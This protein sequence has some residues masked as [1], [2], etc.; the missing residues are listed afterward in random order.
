MVSTSLPA[1]GDTVAGHVIVRCVGEGAMGVV[2]E[3]VGPDGKIVA[4][5]LLKPEKSAHE[6]ILN[7]FRNEAEATG[8]VDH[9]N[10]VTVLGQDH[11]DG[12]HYICMEY[13]DGPPLHE[14]LRTQKQL[15]WR[16]AIEIVIQVAEGLGR[17]H[18][19]G[20]VH[21]DVKPDN[22]LLYRDGR[23]RLTDFGI[24]KDISSL[25]GFLLKGRKV[26]TAVYASPEQCLGKR[27]DPATDMYS[28]GATLYHMICGRFPFTGDSPQ[29]IMNKHVKAPLIPPSSLVPEIPKSL[30]NAIE[31]MMAKRQTDRY[32]SMRRLVEDL[33]FIIQGKVAIGEGRPRVDQSVLRGIRAT[34]RA[35]DELGKPPKVAAETV[36]VIALM[37]VAA[38]IVVLALVS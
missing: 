18:E 21:R 10:V 33:E 9:E 27:L 3:S 7:D 6:E 4:L 17:A 11:E 2:Y 36:L 22:V 16:D 26:G 13:V 30:S 32:S 38:V 19:K 28:L 34:R 37:V 25:K 29:A 8:S 20:L 5:K 12:F 35:K 15:P 1:T 14:V 31:K 23:A 24:V